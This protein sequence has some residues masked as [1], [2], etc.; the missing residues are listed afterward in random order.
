MEGLAGKKDKRAPAPKA[1]IAADGRTLK[2]PPP[3][4]LDY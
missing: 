3:S 2:R 4:D 1:N